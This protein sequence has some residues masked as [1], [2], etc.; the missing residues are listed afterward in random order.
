MRKIVLLA[1]VG[2]LALLAGISARHLPDSSQALKGSVLPDFNF[3]DTSGRQ[4]SI[5][6]WRGKVLVINFWATWCP[7][8][9]KEM[10]E[11]NALQK[12]YSEQGLQFIGIAIE[13]NEPVAKHLAENPVDYPILVGDNAAITLS[14]QLG[15]LVNAVPFSV[16]VGRD[17]RV[18]H[19]HPGEFS[20]KQILD[21]VKDELSA[22]VNR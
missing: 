2:I 5:S 4:H 11:F 13:D 20:T 22:A 9:L 1:G 17:G 3:P 10:P 16:V 12:R 18:L 15:N 21:T 8:C 19:T 7:P 6:E 14:Q